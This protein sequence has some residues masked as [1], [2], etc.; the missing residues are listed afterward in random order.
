MTIPQNRTGRGP[1][2]DVRETSKTEIT[3]GR[4]NKREKRTV[5]PSRQLGF[6]IQD[7]GIN[8]GTEKNWHSTQI[9]SLQSIGTF[10]FLKYAV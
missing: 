7:F 9:V 6:K 2:L 1:L 3:Q 4:G 10:V 5:G 8:P